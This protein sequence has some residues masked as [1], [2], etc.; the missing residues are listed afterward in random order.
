[1]NTLKS[2][3][4]KLFKT[5]LASHKVDLANLKDLQSASAK[6]TKDLAAGQKYQDQLNKLKSEANALA[7]K[8]NEFSSNAKS[9]MPLSANL[10]T[11]IREIEGAAKEL[12]LDA[13]NTPVVQDARNTMN[14]WEEWKKEVAD[15]ATESA[16][17]AKRF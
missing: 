9:G 12:G 11:M 17:Y 4:N 5:E 8:F 1:M 15:M 6:V 7:K 2:V 3:G 13:S 14:A 10:W 16:E